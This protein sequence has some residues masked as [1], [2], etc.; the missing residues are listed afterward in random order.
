MVVYHKCGPSPFNLVGLLWPYW[1]IGGVWGHPTNHPVA[2]QPIFNQTNHPDHSNNLQPTSHPAVTQPIFNQPAIL[3]SLNQSSTNQPSCCHSTNLQPNSHPVV[4]QPIFNQPAILWS[5]NQSSTNQPSCTG[6]Y[7]HGKFKFLYN[8]D[9]VGTIILYYK[10][11]LYH[12]VPTW[13]CSNILY[14]RGTVLR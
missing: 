2:T 12:I 1:F 8:Y 5:L 13:Y 11:L 9:K 4:T 7:T 6:M 14:L 10:V 3:W